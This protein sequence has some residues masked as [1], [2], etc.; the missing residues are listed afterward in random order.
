MKNDMQ[1]LDNYNSLKRR[2]LRSKRWTIFW[3][4]QPVLPDWSQLL[5]CQYF[6]RAF[7]CI[8]D[9][10]VRN[11]KWTLKK[12]LFGVLQPVLPNWSQLLV[13]QE[14]TRTFLYIYDKM[15]NKIWAPRFRA[16]FIF[17]P[18]FLKQV[19]ILVN[20]CL[21]YR[22]IPVNIEKKERLLSRHFGC[23]NPFF[24]TVYYTGL[25]YIY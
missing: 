8:Y 12:L 3:A 15:A 22:H 2:G 16:I 24:Q 10:K 20:R 7:L 23:C 1:K 4:L 13:Y 19:T 9:N 21:S 17:T 5:V 6:M 18:R 25:R 14:F 11:K